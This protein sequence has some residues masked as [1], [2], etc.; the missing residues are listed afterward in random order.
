MHFQPLCTPDLSVKG[1]GAEGEAHP[2]RCKRWSC[3]VCR[4][5]NRAKVIA[6]AG[7]SKP[8]AMLTLT[9]NSNDHATPEAA[10]IAI[11]EGLRLLRLRLSRHP[12]F[13]RFEF[14][15][16]FERHQSGY[17]HLHL[18]IKG[19]FIPWKWL[20]KVWHEITGA[21]IVDIS[22]I[23]SRRKAGWYV[24]KYIGKDLSAF[25]S[26]KR[27]WRSHNYSTDVE[28]EK[29]QDR[30]FGPPRRYE[31]NAHRLRTVMAFEGFTVENVGRS[32]FRWRAPP[33]Y[34]A[35]LSYLLCAAEGRTS[36]DLLRRS[37]I[38]RP[39]T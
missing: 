17:P 5:V 32:G 2:I 35:D 15:A 22:R 13:I 6:I 4:E 30:R 36:A 9:V 10:A 25:P 33:D 39:T 31:A 16:V 34:A 29:P 24:A 23:K 14:L 28:D 38:R 26:C 3:P 1:N 11:K 8:R 27:W 21:Y 19:G 18:L 7:K 37:Q 20:R 12:R